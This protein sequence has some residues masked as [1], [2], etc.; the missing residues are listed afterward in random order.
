MLYLEYLQ[1]KSEA[2]K[3]SITLINIAP[4]SLSIGR[5]TNVEREP[6]EAPINV[7]QYRVECS[8]EKIVRER[9][10]INPEKRRGPK[11]RQN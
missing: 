4:N 8:S 3:P 2:K 7:I 1:S 11:K 10:M 9:D 6:R 5:N